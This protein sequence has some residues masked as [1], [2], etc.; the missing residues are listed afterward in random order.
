[1]RA[2]SKHI[3]TRDWWAIT[4]PGLNRQHIAT[5]ME[6]LDNLARDQMDTTHGYA[7]TEHERYA[8]GEMHSYYQSLHEENQND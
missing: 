8:L 5:V 7:L 2:L 1:M 6:V 4:P 3:I